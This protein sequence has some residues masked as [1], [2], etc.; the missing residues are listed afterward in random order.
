MRLSPFI[1]SLS[2]VLVS[3]WPGLPARGAEPDQAE[4]L[5]FAASSLLPGLDEARDRYHQANPQVTIRIAYAASSSLA[6]Q[7]AAGAPAHLYATADNQWAHYL[8][9]RGHIGPDWPSRWLGNELVV[10]GPG[11]ELSMATLPYTLTQTTALGDLLGAD[12]R[13][14]MGDPDHVPAGRYGKQALES[15]GQWDD[16]RDRLAPTQDAL[17]ATAF[18]AQGAA[19]FGISYVTDGVFTDEI[20]IIASIPRHHHAPIHYGLALVTPG[21][22]RPGDGNGNG[23]AGVNPYAADFFRFLQSDEGLDIFA[24]LGFIT[25]LDGGFDNGHQEGPKDRAKNDLDSGLDREPK[26]GPVE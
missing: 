17:T 14:V 10:I 3:L 13:W 8:A 25:R 11:V 12:E 5:V 20:S 4:I 6:R 21:D 26:G 18:V 7:I 24:N 19:P 1:V 16:L 15:L 23:E 22:G 9:E 2:L